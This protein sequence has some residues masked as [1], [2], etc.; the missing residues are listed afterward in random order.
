MNTR[1]THGRGTHSNAPLSSVIR[2]W[3]MRTRFVAALVIFSTALAVSFTWVATRQT[4]NALYRET[5]HRGRMMLQRFAKDVAD[6]RSLDDPL[7][8]EIRLLV[9][10]NRTM[11]DNALYVQVVFDGEPVIS[12]AAD[13][14]SPPTDFLQLG[15]SVVR[16]RR[17]RGESLYDFF[18]PLPPGE[19]GPSYVNFGLS[20]APVQRHVQDILLKMVWIGVL[21]SAV[22]LLVATWLYRRVFEPLNRLLQSV[23]RLAAGDHGA[24]ATIATRDELE[25]LATEFNRMADAIAQRRIELKQANAQ[26]MRA[27]QA[28]SDFLATMSHEWK[29]PLHAVRGYAQLLLTEVDG[30][31]TKSQRDDVEAMLAAANHLLDL[32]ENILHYIQLSYDEAPNHVELLDLTALARQAWDHV[33][34]AARTRKLILIDELPATLFVHGDRTRLRQVLINIIGNAVQYTPKG[35]ITLKGGGVAGGIWLSVSDSGPGIP[36]TMHDAIFEPFERINDSAHNASDDPHRPIRR[37]IKGAKDGLGLGLTVARRYV[38]S[39]GGTIAVASEPGM[40]STFTIVLP[41]HAHAPIAP[42]ASGPE[43]STLKEVAP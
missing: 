38:Q 16:E 5:K 4:A 17:Q 12:S 39:H 24:R 40:G 20:L 14:W 18:G 13:G 33:R 37:N 35:H 9:L 19:T 1:N 6:T 43:Q 7:E 3:G 15:E 41:G 28:K 22:A 10:A 8:R 27:D 29:T 31:L 25:E 34:P 2:P 42:D 21:F 11:L 36:Q 26:L 30:S 23:R 32:I